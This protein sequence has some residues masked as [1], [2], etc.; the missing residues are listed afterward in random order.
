M[1][2][3]ATPIQVADSYLKQM[4]KRNSEL[5]TVTKDFVLSAKEAFTQVEE[6]I[7]AKVQDELTLEAVTDF[8]ENLKE[9]SG[10][11]V[12][13][14]LG[15]IVSGLKQLPGLINTDKIMNFLATQDPIA[16]IATRVQE[17]FPEIKSEAVLEAVKG[18]LNV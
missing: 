8:M 10:S 5:A 14:V 3:N 9:T 13:D 4:E 17:E 18:Y 2:I 11:S 16:I 15:Q 7:K 6:G 12:Q 1:A